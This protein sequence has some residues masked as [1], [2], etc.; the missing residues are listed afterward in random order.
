MRR[1]LL[2]VPTVVKPTIFGHARGLIGTR[3]CLHDLK[4]SN[5]AALVATAVNRKVSTLG[6]PLCRPLWLAMAIPCDYG[7]IF[8]EHLHSTGQQQEAMFIMMSGFAEDEASWWPDECTRVSWRR[9]LLRSTTTWP[10]DC[11]AEGPMP[12]WLRP[13]CRGSR[14]HFPSITD[15]QFPNGFSMQCLRRG[16]ADSCTGALR[17]VASCAELGRIALSTWP[18]VHLS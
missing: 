7:V 1:F 5:V 15:G 16:D 18:S 12:R 9:R 4:V 13:T 11:E 6:R 3:S 14:L 2:P 8:A 17:G 10:S